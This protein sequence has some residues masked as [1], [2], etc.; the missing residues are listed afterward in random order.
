MAAAGVKNALFPDV[1]QAQRA[2]G[3]TRLRKIFFRAANAA[4]ERLL[5]AKIHFSQATAGE[6][7]KTLFLGQWRD[8][9]ADIASPREYGVGLLAA[10]VALG[11]TSL[12]VALE[13]ASLDIFQTGDTIWIGA[14][15]SV[16][17]EYFDNVTC[18]KNGASVLIALPSGQALAN[19]Y[20]AGLVA[21]LVYVASVLQLGDL[22]PG[23]ETANSSAG[24][25]GYDEVN[26]PP[27]LNSLGAVED[28]FIMTFTSPT[29]FSVAGLYAGALAS[30]VIGADYAPLNSASG[31]P[32]FTLKAAGWVGAWAAGDT[33]TLTTHPAARP[34]WL[35]QVVPAGAAAISAN[36]WELALLGEGA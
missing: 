17:G 29:N 9:Q 13:S 22:A 4:D 23:F 25:G 21:G 1:T 5:N 24:D 8:A 18:I 36:T 34:V 11:A 3:L 14:A 35:R 32:F 2:A 7:C 10:D 6:D 30:G 27:A 19:A 31:K 26:Y 12:T 15:G 28:T 33:F 20:A 16:N